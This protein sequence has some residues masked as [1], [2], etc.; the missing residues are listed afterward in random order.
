MQ[1]PESWL[2]SFVDPELDSEAL[3]RL[4]TMAGL[5]VEAMQPAGPAFSGVVV[6]RVLTAEKHPGADKLKL[7]AVDV[8]DSAP[9]QI[10]CG[11]PNV[12]PGLTVACARVGASLPGLSIKAAKVR[13][14]E[15][16]GMLC[17]ERELGLGDGHGGLME[18]PSCYEVGVDLRTA[19]QLD[20]QLFTIKLTPNRA[21]CLSV[22][23]IA[24]EVSALT[25]K[26]LRAPSAAVVPVKST[27]ARNVVLDSPAD[28][29]R[30]LGR[31]I[32]AVN[33][34][35]TIPDWM[36]S[37][38]ERSGLRPI[39]ALVDITN[40]VM[41]EI[42]QPLHAFD[43]ARLHGAV[44]VRRARP[45][46]SLTLL[47]GQVLKLD[48]DVLLI[49]DDEKALA[50]AGVMGGEHSGIG[51]DTTEIFLESAFFSPDAIAGRARRF[52]FSSDASYRFERGVDFE[53]AGR[54]IER[55]SEL[56]LAI[57]GGEAGPV[58]VAEVQASL[59]KRP[60][61]GVRCS[62]VERVLGIKFG[63][64]RIEAL[65]KGMDVRYERNGENFVV[66][67]P[68]YR[69]DLAIEEDFIEELARLHGYDNI[70]APAPLA[71]V[72]ILPV[73]E[74]KRSVW[75][76]RHAMVGRGYQEVVNFA[77]V[78]AAWERDFAGNDSPVVLAN[79]IASQMGVMRSSLIGGLVG[80]LITNL[81]R[82]TDRVRVF[83][84]GRCFARSESAQVVP[85][86]DQPLRM[87]ALAGGSVA[88]DQWGS[89]SRRTDFFDVKGDLEALLLPAEAEF[90]PAVHPAL[91]PGRSARV[92]LGGRPIG[93]IGELHPRWVQEYDLGSPPVV[94]EIELDAL[95]QRT[96]PKYVTLAN[97]PAVVRDLALVMS[98]RVAARDVLAAM[99][100]HAPAVVRSIELFDLYQ[101]KG[102]PAGEKSLAF[103]MVMQDT[104]KTLEDAEADA[105]VSQLERI[106]REKFSARLRA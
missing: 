87:G 75:A 63:A 49:A 73:P 29:P 72:D 36:R 19:R 97:T 15:S 17:S 2:R 7:C 27:L 54:A 61:V 78:D 76:L 105:V 84:V 46:E 56:V 86:F 62:R 52:G 32:T 100:A 13:G 35:A 51:E 93:W 26:T 83:E 79:P 53:G 102:I 10:V 14:I 57:C 71:R 38:L 4:L 94:F 31:V 101:G 91:H 9:L 96:L 21:D 85:G 25:G 65:L 68:S 66:A 18:L 98:E 82:R 106:A 80:N 99:R 39:S 95:L 59:P 43:N 5:E 58:T 12:A 81:K 34:R 33:P 11:A 42:G 1:F 30:Y 23:G 70:P 48:Q 20:E 90:E 74:D 45:G 60:A 6:G 50:M 67:P 88:P 8:G 22:L 92:A 69:F 16:F 3:G 89:P 55:A 28:C 47:N 104:Q 103:R 40:Y 77:F 24:R 44:H 37:R 64:D 41:L